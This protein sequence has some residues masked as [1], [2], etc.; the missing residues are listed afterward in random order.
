[1][2]YAVTPMHIQR[3]TYAVAFRPPNFSEFFFE[4]PVAPPVDLSGLEAALSPLLG[5]VALGFG[6]IPLLLLGNVDL[7]IEKVT[8]FEVGY[9][10]ILGRKAFLT[11][12]YYS[13]EIEDFTTSPLPSTCNIRTNC[14]AQ[15]GGVHELR[16]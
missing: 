9:N 5:G 15:L 4:L 1:M 3:L 11:V 8:G 6:N 2:G 12:S 13:S 10:A 14:I 16:H 7:E